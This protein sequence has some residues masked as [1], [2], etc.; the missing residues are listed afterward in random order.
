MT[1]WTMRVI[2][3]H[4]EVER[5]VKM[6]LHEPIADPPERPLVGR[7]PYLPGSLAPGRRREMDASCLFAKPG[8]APPGK[9]RKPP[10]GDSSR[11]G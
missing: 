5:W 6:T 4:L 9:K 1:G 7:F 8:A 2:A 3:T 10:E 11:S